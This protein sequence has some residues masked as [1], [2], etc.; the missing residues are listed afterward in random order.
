MQARHY[1]ANAVIQAGSHRH[2]QLHR[3]SLA[4]DCRGKD[5]MRREL[6]TVGRP[7]QELELLIRERHQRESAT[8]L[9]RSSNIYGRAALDGLAQTRS[10]I[11]AKLRQQI[12]ID[13]DQMV[14]RR[15]RRPGRGLIRK[16]DLD[17]QA[18]QPRNPR[19]G[20]RQFRVIADQPALWPGQTRV[21][22]RLPQLWRRLEIGVH[23]R[24]V[25]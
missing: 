6:I 20:G 12:E 15:G 16:A 1:R 22:W 19:G 14:A 23:L 13:R 8:R 25:H 3:D 2:A 5:R 24:V 18:A 9:K 11:G 4:R 17:L 10:H 7:V 21:T